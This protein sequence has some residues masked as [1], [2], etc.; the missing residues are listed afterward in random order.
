MKP[1]FRIVGPDGKPSRRKFRSAVEAASE[2]EI[3]FPGTPQNFNGDE[4]GWEIEVCWPKIS[5]MKST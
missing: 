2:A 4:G 5:E 3:L 1:K